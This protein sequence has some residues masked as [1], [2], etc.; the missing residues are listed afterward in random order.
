MIETPLNIRKDLKTDVIEF[1]NKLSRECD[2]EAPEISLDADRGKMKYSQSPERP[3][4][5]SCQDNLTMCPG[6]LEI[7]EHWN[8]P[9]GLTGQP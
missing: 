9:E 8:V 7:L 5:N 4:N 1:W 3:V 6:H 2:I